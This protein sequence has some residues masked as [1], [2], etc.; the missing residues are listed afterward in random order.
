MVI[1]LLLLSSSSFYFS[2]T[3]GFVLEGFQ[4]PFSNETLSDT[5]STVTDI[6]YDDKPRFINRL[7][8]PSK[9]FSNFFLSGLK[10]YFLFL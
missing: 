8:K 7:Y 6:L 5:L 2:S 9:Q 1:L 10:F 3:Q 4:L